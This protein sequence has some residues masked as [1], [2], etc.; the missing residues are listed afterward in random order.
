MRWNPMGRSGNLEDQRGGSGARGP[1]LGGLGL[2]GV[3]IVVVI[4]LLTKQNP[5]AL[6]GALDQQGSAATAP[7]TA[8]TDPA[9]EK[10]VEF[11]S[12]VLDDAQ[13]MWAA[14]FAAA[15]KPWRDAKLVLFRDQVESACGYAQAASGPFYC[16]GDEKVYIDLGFYHELESRFGAPGDFAE[17]YVLAHEIGHHVQRLLGTEAEVRSAQQ[18]DPSGA[19]ALSVGLELQA[20]CLAGVWGHSATAAGRLEAGDVDEGLQ[21]AAAVG[22]DR[23][24]RA[25]SGSVHPES[26]TH[27]SS[28]QRV[29]WFRRGLAAG[30]ASACDSFGAR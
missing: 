30:E 25:S 11:V 5:L 17:A 26:W 2:G 18:R 7:G 15:G 24:Q 6:L 21:A 16:P 19:N 4:A 13:A 29:T 28:A 27:G 10:T 22:D 14:K 20:D 3:V 9:E 1:N 8:I 23:L 12:F